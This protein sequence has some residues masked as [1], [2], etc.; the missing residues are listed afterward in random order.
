MWSRFLI[1]PDSFKGS[2]SSPE[3]AKAIQEGIKEIFPNANIRTQALADGGEGTLDMLSAAFPLQVIETPLLDLYGE[4]RLSKVYFT[5]DIAFL[6]AA[7]MAGLRERKDLFRASSKGFGEELVLAAKRKPK[8]I[9]LGIGGTGVNDGGM[10]LLDA[11]G[12]AFY[13][14]EKRLCPSLKSLLLVDRI[15]GEPATLP[16]LEVACD[17]ENPLLGEKGASAVYGPQKGLEK[18]DLPRVEEAM[19]RYAALLERHF[20]KMVKDLP[21]AGA[22]GGL[23][24]ALLLL[25]AKLR[26]GFELLSELCELDKQIH[27]A[28]V[29]ITGEGKFDE[30]SLYG[31]GPQELA[32]KAKKKGKVVLG[33]FGSVDADS[34]SFDGLFSILHKPVALEEAMDKEVTRENLRRT[35]RSC[36]KLLALKK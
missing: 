35:A 32:K 15:E 22:A 20:G 4:K 28:D 14:G 8:T 24:F 17:V 9:L 18:K 3:A 19:R 16:P 2:L 29:I 25:G 1:A 30:Q 36:A 10:G 23:G 13:H 7:N 34:D 27:W 31:K 21:G 6:E 26:P 11:L 12:I 5:E 33:F